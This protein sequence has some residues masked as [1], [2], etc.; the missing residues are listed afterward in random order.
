MITKITKRNGEVVDFDVNKLL[1]W[2]EWAGVVGCDWFAI[3]SEAY[4][5]LPENP[6]TVELQD[7][8]IKACLDVEDTPHLM[9]AGRLLIG[10]VS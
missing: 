7:A 5:K 6:T 4:K 8:M 2:S 10:H 3:A 1:K 9:M